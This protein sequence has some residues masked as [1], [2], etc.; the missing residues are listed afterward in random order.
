MAGLERKDLVT[1]QFQA[2]LNWW[3]VNDPDG[4]IYKNVD[5]DRYAIRGNQIQ[6][7]NYE[8]QRCDGC[9]GFCDVELPLQDGTTL[10]YGFNHDH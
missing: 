3:E 8:N 6:E 4:I 10:L 9:C 2:V 1:A 7:I 5:N